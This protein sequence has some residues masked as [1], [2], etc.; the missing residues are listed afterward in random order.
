MAKSKSYMSMYRD[1]KRLLD[2]ALDERGG[3]RVPH[4]MDVSRFDGWTLEQIE[5]RIRN[6]AHEE[7]FVL[8]ESG[9]I[10]SAYRGN[11]SSVAFYAQEFNV[12]GATVTHGH[13]KG[14]QDFGGTLSFKD[15][16]NMAQSRWAEHR[17]TASGQGEMNYIMRRTASSDASGLRAQIA[18]DKP[19]IRANMKTTYDK[20]YNEA[21]ASGGS[22]GHATH[23]ARQA[24][25]GVLNRYWKDTLP[26]FGY[27]YVTRKDPYHYGR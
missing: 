12:E 13:P 17:A 16:N 6:L 19:A 21:R 4:P 18:S 26:Q 24:S 11:R 23:V 22:I 1:R 5:S 20:A 2:G 8:D 10:V 27:Q 9:A 3:Q 14:M 15:V 7:L 25:V